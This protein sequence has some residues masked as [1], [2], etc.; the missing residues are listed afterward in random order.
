MPGAVSHLTCLPIR[1]RKSRHIAVSHYLATGLTLVLFAA[2]DFLLCAF[3]LVFTFEV[4]LALAAGADAGAAGVCA[5]RM[6]PTLK[7]EAKISLVIWFSFFG[8]GFISASHNH[9]AAERENQR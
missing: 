6:A 9:L 8:E 5:A 1:A 3:L 4:V 2:V 7:R